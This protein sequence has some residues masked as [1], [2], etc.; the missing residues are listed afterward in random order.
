MSE[1][2]VRPLVVVESN[3]VQKGPDTSMTGSNQEAV[4]IHSGNDSI[5]SL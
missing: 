2:F 3:M 1:D 4:M 5:D